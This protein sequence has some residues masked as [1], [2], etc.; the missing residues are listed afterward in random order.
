M[1][2]AKVLQQSAVTSAIS[3]TEVRKERHGTASFCCASASSASLSSA[4]WILEVYLSSRL[5]E[6]DLL[7]GSLQSFL[8]F[9]SGEILGCVSGVSKTSSHQKANQAKV[10]APV[11]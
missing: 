8:A 6:F 5:R 10:M 2:A 3:G 9:S 4:D 7:C 1:N 11:A